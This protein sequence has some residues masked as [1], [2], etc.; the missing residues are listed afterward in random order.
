LAFLPAVETIFVFCD[1]GGRVS[2]KGKNE[3]HFYPLFEWFSKARVVP[4]TY[5][6]KFQIAT[7]CSAG[8]VVSVSAGFW[9][10]FCLRKKLVLGLFRLQVQFSV[11]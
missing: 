4:V 10:V 9:R 5:L 7:R 8:V 3:V 2:D 11:C 1:A 6:S